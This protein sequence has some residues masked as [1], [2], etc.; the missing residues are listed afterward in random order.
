MQVEDASDLR[1]NSVLMRAC[2]NDK[3]QFCKGTL[4]ELG[5]TTVHGLLQ[6]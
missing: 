4:H 2:S 6:P 5:L 1:L 3:K